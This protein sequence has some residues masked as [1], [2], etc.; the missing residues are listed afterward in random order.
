MGN[1]HG[2]RGGESRSDREIPEYAS[3]SQ[4]SDLTFSTRAAFRF[5]GLSPAQL[6]PTL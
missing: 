1:F 2:L 4:R 3:G 6:P 5:A